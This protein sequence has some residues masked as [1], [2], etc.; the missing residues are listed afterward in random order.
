MVPT[1]TDP[2]ELLIPDG[3][4]LDDE[5]GRPAN[6]VSRHDHE[7]HLHRADLGA[8]DDLH[9]ADTGL[10]QEPVVEGAAAGALGALALAG[11]RLPADVA[12]DVVADEAVTGA[13]DDHRQHEDA[14]RHPGH[15]GAGTPGLD[16]AGPAVAGLGDVVHLDHGEDEVLRRAQHEAQRPGGGDHEARAA[17]GLLQRLQRVAHGDVAVRGHDDQHV[18]RHEHDEHLQVLH[19]AAQPVGAPEPVGDV[20][21]HLRQ[22]LEESH[23][24]VR[25]AQVANEEVHAGRLAGR[26]VQRQQHATVPQHGHHEDH[27]QHSDLHLGQLLVAPVPRR[28]PAFPSGVVPAGVAPGETHP[29]RAA[30]PRP[31]RRVAPFLPPRACAP[32]PVRSLLPALAARGAP[33]SLPQASPGAA[34]HR[35]TEL[36]SVPSA[37]AFPA[38]P[39]LN[40]EEAGEVRSEPLKAVGS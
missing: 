19:H 29:V 27:G 10:E 21:A 11:H 8:G 7:S 34:S 16:E 38:L 25:Q 30:A 18:R 32:D 12:P 9:A 28:T 31:P 15:I 26:A 1:P 20:P 39:L 37:A 40:S 35:P 36:L 14:A 4:H 23:S 33:L 5:E 17:R 22:H 24:Q 13:Q 2:G 6:D 3:P